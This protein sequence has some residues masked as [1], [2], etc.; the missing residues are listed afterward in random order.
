L[1]ESFS[2][3]EISELCAFIIFTTA[4]Q[5]FGAIMKLEA[6]ETGNEIALSIQRSGKSIFFI[7]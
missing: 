4:Q 3:G 7:S 6:P 1:R 2:E 5:Y